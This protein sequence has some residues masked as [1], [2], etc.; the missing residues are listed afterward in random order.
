MKDKMNSLEEKAL[1]SSEIFTEYLKQAQKKS[2]SIKEKTIDADSAISNFK[3]IQTKIKINPKL[4]NVFASLQ[5]RFIKNPT[6]AD[7]VFIEA[8]LS[9][10]LE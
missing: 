9:L 8:V 2:A 10:N 7:P 5:E 1:A 3:D 6:G 4:R